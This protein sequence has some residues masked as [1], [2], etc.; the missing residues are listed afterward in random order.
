MTEWT[1]TSPSGWCMMNLHG[2]ED[3]TI[4]DGHCRLGPTQCGCGCH[5]GE[6]VYRKQA[7]T[8]PTG[9]ELDAFDEDCE[10]EEDPAA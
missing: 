10:D 2:W 4:V 3:G 1:A 5:R 7:W 9:D 6:E 8:S